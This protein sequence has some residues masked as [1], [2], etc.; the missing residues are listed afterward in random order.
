MSYSA[1]AEQVVRG[2]TGGL[3]LKAPVA[4]AEPDGTDC[5]EGIGGGFREGRTAAREP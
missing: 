1:S 5:A 4:A 2:G 3:Q